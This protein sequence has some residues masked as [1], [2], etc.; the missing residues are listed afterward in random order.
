MFDE[1][2]ITAI[3]GMKGDKCFINSM[4]ISFSYSFFPTYK[5]IA[6]YESASVCLELSEWS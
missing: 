4:C 5:R 1:K 6:G 2:R 3:D